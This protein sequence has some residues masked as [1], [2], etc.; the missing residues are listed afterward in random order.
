[1]V[2]SAGWAFSSYKAKQTQYSLSFF[3]SIVQLN[4]QGW[5]EYHWTNVNHT[6]ICEP[7][8]MV[9][10]MEVCWS[11]RFK[12]YVHTYVRLSEPRGLKIGRCSSKIREHGM[13]AGQSKTTAVNGKTRC[14][15]FSLCSKNRMVTAGTVTFLII[16]V[17]WKSITRSMSSTQE[18]YNPFK[19][20]NHVR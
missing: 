10:E 15:K 12:P 9:K 13:N 5:I 14:W 1:M 18:A 16:K 6:T 3:S 11:I 8:T 19:W 2:D 17:L 7:I 20:N 4:S